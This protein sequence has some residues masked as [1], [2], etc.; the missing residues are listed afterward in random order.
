M[1][2]TLVVNP[3]SSSK[4]YALFRDGRLVLRIDVSH[5]DKDIRYEVKKNE[6]WVEDMPI[7]EEDYEN[8]IY[9]VIESTKKYLCIKDTIDISY[10]GLRLVAPG[11]SFQSHQ[12]FTE[13]LVEVL[14]K[15]ASSAPLH[16]PPILAE[17]RI[18]KKAL[19]Q[20]RIVAAS[21]SAFHNTMPKVASKY[22]IPIFDQEEFEIQRYGYHGLSVSSVV[23]RLR[24]FLSYDYSRVIVCHIGSGV[25]VTAVKDGLSVD[26]SMGFAPGSGLVMASRAG[27]LETGALLELI[28]MKSLSLHEA[29]HYIQHQGGLNALAGE[30]DIRHLLERVARKDEQ[31]EHALSHF[32]YNIRKKIGS[33]IAVLGGVDVIVYTATA[34]ERSPVLRSHILSP[35]SDLGILLDQERNES[36]VKS[37]MII[38]SN[39]SNVKVVVVPTDELGEID[40][41]VRTITG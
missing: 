5:T 14:E 7:S 29:H 12:F 22:S 31:A 30:S 25:S 4:K 6:S 41:I 37:E 20:I 24:T 16:I 1:A 8:C 15:K 9:K 39:D 33:M 3:G 27:D 36:A 17:Y 35:L 10:V 21:D 19:P 34:G 13:S 23:N 18:L 2:V 38:S 26:T 11:R 32:V 40:R 28:R